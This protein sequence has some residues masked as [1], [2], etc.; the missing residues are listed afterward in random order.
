MESSAPRSSQEWT[1][2]IAER[3][4]GRGAAVSAPAFA[5][6][7]RIALQAAVESGHIGTVE[8]LLER[9][10]EVNAPAFAEQR[11]KALQVAAGI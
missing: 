4:V 9:G 1:I 7:G 6:Q 11:R 3:L 2:S 8:W 10:A 5:K